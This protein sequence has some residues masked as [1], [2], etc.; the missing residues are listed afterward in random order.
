MGCVSTSLLECGRISCKLLPAGVLCLDP[1]HLKGGRMLGSNCVWLGVA[2]SVTFQAAC[3]YV[4][5]S[6]ERLKVA[7]FIERRQLPTMRY[8]HMAPS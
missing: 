1:I 7:G 6:T 8:P 3:V 4:K 2:N 5:A